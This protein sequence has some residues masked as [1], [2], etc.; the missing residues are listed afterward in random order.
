MAKEGPRSRELAGVETAHA[1]KKGSGVMIETATAGEKQNLR[2]DSGLSIMARVSNSR[3][4]G[5][6]PRDKAVSAGGHVTLT[7][8]FPVGHL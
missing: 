6:T 2:R 3:D 8:S 1:P 7:E 5:E 4:R